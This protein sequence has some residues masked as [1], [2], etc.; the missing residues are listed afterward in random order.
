MKNEVDGVQ[1]SRRSKL[2][3][4]VVSI[5]VSLCI[6]ELVS[7]WRLSSIPD[8]DAYDRAVTSNDRPPESAFGERER[9]RSQAFVLHPYLGYVLNADPKTARAFEANRFGFLGREPSLQSLPDTVSIGIFGGSAAALL[10]RNGDLGE[11]LEK[12]G[13][14]HEQHVAVICAALGGYKQP[15]ALMA[16]AYLLTLGVDL[17]VAVN[18]DGANDVSV[19]VSQFDR[20][21]AFPAYPG[22]RWTFLS[23]ESLDPGA[24][25]AMGRISVLED[26]KGRWVR[27]FDHLGVLKRSFT[28]RLLKRVV[29]NHKVSQIR[30][31]TSRLDKLQSNPVEQYK[32]LGPQG[33]FNG[34]Q[35]LTAAVDIWSRSS[36]EMAD[37][38]AGNGIE[39]FHFLQPA[40][41]CGTSKTFTSEEQNAFKWWPGQRENLEQGYSLLEKAGALLRTEGVAFTDLT[42][43]F[44]N[45]NGTVYVDNLHVNRLG[46]HIIAAEIADVIARRLQRGMT[47][48]GA[49]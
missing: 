16:L 19:P 3:L 8:L 22:P 21:G 28:A 38:C 48:P 41:C 29:I 30:L 4:L 25:K 37:L 33:V 2:L 42:G 6:L 26:D 47:S 31:E 34:S 9:E 14:F 27:F 18:M 49:N 45:E 17:D 12:R 43:V 11:E 1:L 39:Y 44:D 24:V 32:V 15:Q 40:S 35:I 23:R 36:R 10:C 20:F 7:W 46:N 5:V 13:L